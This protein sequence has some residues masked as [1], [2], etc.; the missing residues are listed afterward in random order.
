MKQKFLIA[1]AAFALAAGNTAHAVEKDFNGD[2][3]SDLVWGDTITGQRGFWFMQ[4]QNA[5]GF[6]WVRNASGQVVP[7]LPVNWHIVGTS[8]F[9]GDGNA[10][11]VWQDSIT[12][13]ARIWF[14]KNGVFSYSKNM[15]VAS[16]SGAG[17]VPLSL[18]IVAVGQNYTNYVDITM[19]APDGT[20]WI[21]YYVDGETNGELAR[22][23]V[24]PSAAADLNCPWS[25]L[26]TSNGMVNTLPTSGHLQPGWRIAGEFVNPPYPI[27]LATAQADQNGVVFENT[28]DGRI[29]FAHLVGAPGDNPMD[30]DPTYCSYSISSVRVPV[31]WH[32]A[33]SG[34]FFGAGNYGDSTSK[35]LGS[36]TS[37]FLGRVCKSCLMDKAPTCR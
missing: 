16:A 21:Q 31:G 5:T 34:K 25:S 14:L 2:G 9:L 13:A 33:G 1:M 22:L 23:N 6:G 24:A 10:D 37:L 4:N 30:T 20:I 36:Y 29:A 28:I 32:I 26:L 27:Y 15:Q 7:P 12:G 19:V 11:L 35:A 8:D 17:M 3:Y 18:P